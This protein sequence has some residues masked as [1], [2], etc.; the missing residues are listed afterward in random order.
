MTAFSAFV[1]RHN[2][3][4]PLV[5]AFPIDVVLV[6]S[7]WWNIRWSH[8]IPCAVYIAYFSDMIDRRHAFQFICEKVYNWSTALN[9]HLKY[10]ISVAPHTDPQRDRDHRLNEDCGNSLW[11]HWSYHSLVLRHMADNQVCWTLQSKHN[12]QSVA[13]WGAFSNQHI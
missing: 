3:H 7:F 6:L 10:I 2:H 9:L 11:M 12:G 8:D 13:W 4:A 1:G 5:L